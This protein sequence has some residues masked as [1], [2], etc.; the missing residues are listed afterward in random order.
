MA[1][2]SRRGLEGMPRN[3]RARLYDEQRGAAQ[4]GGERQ[5]L[6]IEHEQLPVGDNLVLAISLLGDPEITQKT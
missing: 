1:R 5:T 2:Y 4:G 3:A 6:P